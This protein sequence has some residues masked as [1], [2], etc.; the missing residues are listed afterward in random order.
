MDDKSCASY[1]SALAV[2]RRG[3]LASAL[4]WVAMPSAL[5]QVALGGQPDQGN[6]VVVVFLRGGADGLNLLVPHFED[7]YYRAR[8]ALALAKKDLIPVDDRFGLN[9]ALA[10]LRPILEDGRL[11]FVH[12][13]GSGDQTRSHFEAMNTMERG[14]ADQRGEAS[15][16]IARHLASTPGEGRPLRAVA[17]GG[18][19]P[20][21][22]SGAT[23]AVSLGSLEDY[24][25]Q[26]SPAFRAALGQM[27]AQHRD[28]ISVAGRETLTVLERLNRLDYSAYQPAGSAVYPETG[29]CQGLRQA[30]FLL[31]A[32][33]GV[34]FACLDI[35]GWDTHVAQGTTTGWLTGLLDEVARGLA[36]FVADLGPRMERTTVIVQT[37]F[38]RR[39]HENA[40]L[41]TDHGRGGVMWLLGGGV[42][43]G[44]VYGTWPGLGPDDLEGPGDLRVTTDYRDPVF[45]VLAK[46]MGAK[47]PD[48]VFPGFRPKPLG[49]VG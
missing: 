49:I 9:P 23:Q 4:S 35:G 40:G 25:L 16:W 21:S 31:K 33:V 13:C 44:K 27:Y 29:L 7:A 5:S 26:G 43:G 37:E 34:E 30:A 22:L 38:G 46:R 19:A 36:A 6:A 32:G 45:E 20:D 28:E 48:A 11:A 17:L 42:K 8:P 18:V 47:S 1:R 39:L 3:L 14:L 24:R 12:A 10:P 2:S 41:G 15:G